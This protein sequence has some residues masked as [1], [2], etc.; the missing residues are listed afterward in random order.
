[1]TTRPSSFLW[2]VTAFLEAIAAAILVDLLLGRWV[3]GQEA[4]W[5]SALVLALSCSLVAL[6]LGVALLVRGRQR[7]V[8]PW[9][10]ASVGVVELL[11]SALLWLRARG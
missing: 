7:R 4:G 2:I 10:L 8:V 6:A 11:I 5:M 3:H 9:V 1:V